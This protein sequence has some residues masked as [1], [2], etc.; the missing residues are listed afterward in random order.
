MIISSTIRE[1]IDELIPILR[2][3]DAL[4]RHLGSKRV[5]RRAQLEQLGTVSGTQTMSRCLSAAERLRSGRGAMRR[6]KM[7]CN[8][9]SAV[10]LIRLERIAGDTGSK[11]LSTRIAG[12]GG[13]RF[14][15]APLAM[16]DPRQTDCN[17]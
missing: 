3:A 14:F 10:A 15:D 13:K 1:K 5:A 17:A 16:D 7:P 11:H 6:P 12:I 4:F 2:R 9:A 8:V